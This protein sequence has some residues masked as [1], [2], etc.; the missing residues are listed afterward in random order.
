MSRRCCLTVQDVGPV[1]GTDLHLLHVRAGRGGRQVYGRASDRLQR[2]A[3]AGTALHR[4]YGRRVQR[5][6]GARDVM[7]SIT[8]S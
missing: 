7:L 4:C 2:A 3:D 6:P 5:L 8:A 1:L